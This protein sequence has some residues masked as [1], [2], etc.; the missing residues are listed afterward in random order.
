MT[1]FALEWTG[2]GHGSEA[3]EAAACDAAARFCVEAGIDPAAAWAENVASIEA[4]DDPRGNWWTIESS[5]IIAMC[6]AGDWELVP[7]NVS[8]IWRG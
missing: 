2:H 4:G 5:A 3:D 1:D 8:L 7:E 6:Q